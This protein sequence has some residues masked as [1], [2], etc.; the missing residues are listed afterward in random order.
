M[1]EFLGAKVNDRKLRL[2]QIA[3]CRRIWDLL[4]ND[5]REAVC[6]AEQY[7]D[8]QVGD[9]KRVAARKRISTIAKNASLLE[10]NVGYAAFETLEKTVFK[11]L[12]F[13][14]CAVVFGRVADKSARG[15]KGAYQ[16]AYQA[17][18]A[19]E[20][21]LLRCVFGNPF[22]RTAFKAKWKTAD[23]IA[24]AQQMYDSRDFIAMPVLADA[25][26]DA[27]CDDEAILKHCGGPG[28]HFRGCWPVDMLL[29][30]A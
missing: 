12:P 13:L 3:C 10:I 18:E 20:A 6:V 16:K 17:E 21:D 2:F 4:P 26:Q 22:R 28:P 5:H 19:A 9:K 29:G 30:K 11:R 23:V 27:G 24:L 14:G 15:K 8:G 7:A 25:L 1:I